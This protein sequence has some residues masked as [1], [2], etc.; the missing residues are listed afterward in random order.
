[1][2]MD[3]F[4][5][6]MLQ[7]FSLATLKGEERLALPYRN[8][9]VGISIGLRWGEGMRLT[10]IPSIRPSELLY[11]FFGSQVSQCRE[12]ITSRSASFLE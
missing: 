12:T 10:E 6:E 9:L 4:Q 7:F 1:M 11:Q 3:P 8:M 2:L 5:S